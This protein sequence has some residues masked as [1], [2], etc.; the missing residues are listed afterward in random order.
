MSKILEFIFNIFFGTLRN[1]MRIK[2]WYL[3][4]YR[5]QV[6]AEINPY[7]SCAAHAGTFWLQNINHEYFSD[8]TPDMY[9]KEINS[10]EYLTWTRK[11]LKNG[12]WIAAKYKGNLNQVWLIQAKFLSD[13]IWASGITDKEVIFND[14]TNLEIIKNALDRSPVIINMSPIYK[15][16]KL[17]HVVLVVDYKEYV[18]TI[19][20]S[21]G[22]P[23]NNYADGHIGHGDDVKLSESYFEK[24]KGSFSIYLN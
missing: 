11:N 24:V 5:N 21:F 4:K 10:K 19:D 9:S 6:Q 15:G 14:T 18:F 12:A 3:N 17:G 20:D 16:I 8:Y 2:G 1:A 13:K 22:N 23:G 7:T